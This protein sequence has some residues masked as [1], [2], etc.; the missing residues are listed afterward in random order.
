MAKVLELQ[1]QSFL[2]I[3]KVDFLQD[4]LV[5]SPCSQRNSQAAVQ[6]NCLSRITWCN[7]VQEKFLH[8]SKLIKNVFTFILLSLMLL[9]SSHE[10]LNVK[11][12]LMLQCCLAL[13]TNLISCANYISI[14]LNSLSQIQQMKKTLRTNP[15]QIFGVPYYVISSAEVDLFQHAV[16]LC[17]FLIKN[18]LNGYFEHFA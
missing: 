1:Y 3:F 13:T 12:I 16:F 2:W 8:P 11:M 6:K 7:S 4:W 17:A 5:W 9:F 18:T 10:L 15:T 14:P